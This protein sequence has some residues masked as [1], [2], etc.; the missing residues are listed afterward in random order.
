VLEYFEQCG[1]LHHVQVHRAGLN[2]VFGDQATRSEQLSMYGLDARGL[3]E[4][5]RLVLQR[6]DHVS[7][8]K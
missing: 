4:T 5:A 7:L 1:E 2:D 6:Q 8:V 3:A